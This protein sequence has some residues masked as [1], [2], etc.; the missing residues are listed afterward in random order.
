MSTQSNHPWRASL[1]TAGSV[2]LAVI[3]AL[4]VVGPEIVTFVEEQ[5][6]G[7]PAVG[8]VAGVSA[9]IVGLSALLNRIILLPAVDTL[10]TRI[11]LGPTPK[12]EPYVEGEGLF[13]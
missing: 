2:L 12:K 11:G 3:A 5:F 10:L 6:P 1:R 4:A 8:V 9:F 7:S 13:Q